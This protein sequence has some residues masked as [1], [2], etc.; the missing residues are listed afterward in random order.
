M[1]SS[2]IPECVDTINVPEVTPQDI[3]EFSAFEGA[4]P[5]HMATFA[6]KSCNN[7][8]TIY[9]RTRPEGNESE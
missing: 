4:K 2:F 7:P 8:E 5:C 1:G 3:E 9:F 6:H